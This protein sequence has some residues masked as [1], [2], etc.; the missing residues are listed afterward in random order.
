MKAT[1]LT[2]QR[3]FA[4]VFSVLALL[5]VTTVANAANSGDSADK[6]VVVKYL[7]TVD[8]QPVFQVEVKNEAAEDLIISLEN[9]DGDV[10]YTQRVKD[11]SFSKK[12]QLMTTD[13]EINLNLYVYS[14]KTKTKQ[15]YQINKVTRTVDDV[16]V[17]ERKY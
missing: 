17:N 6:P 3:S 7:G 2:F 1:I 9:T 15:L 11:K 16:V 14:T 10:L 8:A 5:S 13:T 12:I 4:I